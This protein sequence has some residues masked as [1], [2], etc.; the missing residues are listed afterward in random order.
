VKH[1]YNAKNTISYIQDIKI[2]NAF[3]DGV[4]NIKTVEEIAMKKPRTVV[5]LLAVA[6]ICIE[7]SEAW[8]W[9]LESRGKG[10]SKNKQDD[11][12][13]NTTDRGDHKDRGYLGNR[14]QQ[15]S[16]QKEK[17]SFC[18]PDD[19]ENWCKIHR[20]SEH[21]LEE[22][23]TFLDRKKMPPLA[24]LVA[25]EPRQD[26]HRQ[27]NPATT[28]EQMREI[29]VI[30]GGSMSIASKTQGKKLE[31]EISLAQRIE[32]GRKMKWSD[33]DI[34]FGPED[35]PKTELSER[36]LSFVIK[37][38]IGRHKVGKTLIDN[39]TSLNFIMWKT[40]IETGLNLKDLTP[41]HDTFH[42]VIPG[43]SSTPIGRIDLE[44]SCRIGDNKHKEMLM[45]E[46]ANFDIGY[47]CILG[48]PFLLKF[49]TVIHTTYAM[50][51][52][53]SPKSVIAIKANQCDALACES[54]TLTHV[55]QF[56][57]KAAQEQ[58]T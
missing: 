8:A 6:D 48:R 58:A 31:R 23:K 17:R 37:L 35:H 4:N 28:D 13:V 34:S 41:I 33:V 49:I 30:F 47:N 16:D 14:Q 44:V 53:L 12:E 29:N 27:A 1:F 5:D 15:S 36:N 43:K 57:E 7:A 52:M 26:E 54:S 32:P 19:A 9:L 22:C 20:T 24:A 3:C 11:R 42:G 46:I 51:K 40:F 50:M 18:H 45:F 56:G 39:G 2:V 38:P 25:Q 10:P 55:K 21:D